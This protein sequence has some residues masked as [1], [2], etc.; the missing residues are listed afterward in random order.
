MTVAATGGAVIIGASAGA[1][2]ALSLIL[3]ALP[4]DFARPILVIVH[5]PPDKP[6]ALAQILDAKCRLPAVEVGDKDP[7]VPGVIHVA[8]PNYHMLIEDEGHFALS[9][10]AEVLFSRPSIDVS[11]ESACDIWGDRLTCIVLTGANQDGARGARMIASAGGTVIV[12]NPTSA[13][14]RAMPEAAIAAC[15]QAKIMTLPEIAR[16]LQEHAR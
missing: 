12:Q 10:E 9:G 14:A 4:A 3:P 7:V 13:Y 8:P 15:P 11:F 5:I 1:L 16:H 6:S 2:D